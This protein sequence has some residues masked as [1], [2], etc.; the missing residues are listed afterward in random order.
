MLIAPHNSPTAAL[1]LANFR[2]LEARIAAATVAAGRNVES[3]TVI[4]VSK[5]HDAEAVRAAAAAGSRHV[6]ESYA[7][8]AI[9]KMLLLADLPVTWHF[10][11][12]LQAN[13]TR[14][15]AERFDWVHGVDRL[16]LAERL[17]A[18]RPHYAHPLQ[19]CLQINIAGEDLKAGVPPAEASALALAVAALPRLQLRGLMC[20]LPADLSPADNRLHFA[21]LRALLDQINGTLPERSLDSL[22]MGMSGDF[23]EAIMEGATMVRIGTAIFGPRI[24]PT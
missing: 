15:I 4:A 23:G 5:G 12:R 19:V 2:Q 22:S 20:I 11:G 7:Q 10:I 13:K 21:A 6:G 9:P 16:R 1:I 24:G 14:A 17:S 18:Q 3:V 8:E